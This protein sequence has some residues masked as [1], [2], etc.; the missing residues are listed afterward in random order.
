MSLTAILAGCG[1]PRPENTLS[2]EVTGTAEVQAVPD[3]FIVHAAAM[4]EGHDVSIISATVNDQITKV[5]ALANRLGIDKQQVQ[6]LSLQITPQWQYQP[7]RVLTGYQASRDIT[8]TLKG[9]DQYGRLIDGLVA[10]GINN[11]SQT[12]AILSNRHEL[13]LDALASAVKDAQAKAD[14][15]AAATGLKVG[16]PVS[17]EVESGDQGGPVPMRSLAMKAESSPFEPGQTTL[18]QRVNITYELK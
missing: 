13:M 17:I 10:I 3:R 14:K 9:L 18:Q 5:L 12:Q 16:R 6:A 2:V 7:K 1:H 8:I 11:I 15:I 4:Q